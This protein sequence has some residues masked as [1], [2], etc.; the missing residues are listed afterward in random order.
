MAEK[1][2]LYRVTCKARYNKNLTDKV[3]YIKC[4]SKK[5]L[6]H[7]MLSAFKSEYSEYFGYVELDIREIKDIPEIIQVKVNLND[8]KKP[9]RK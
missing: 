7:S 5:I 6:E 4:T 2:K 1:V 8:K 9:K 3:E